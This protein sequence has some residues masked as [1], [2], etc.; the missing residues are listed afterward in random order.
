MTVYHRRRLCYNTEIALKE[1]RE[2][3]LLKLNYMLKN[4]PVMLLVVGSPS[5]GLSWHLID[6]AS[7]WTRR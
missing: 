6:V 7:L 2:E 3:F 1:Y 4:D 5:L